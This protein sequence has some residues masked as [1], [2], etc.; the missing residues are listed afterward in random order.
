M[1]V[2]EIS[3][4]YELQKIRSAQDA[5][6]HV[7]KDHLRVTRHRHHTRG[8]RDRAV[9]GDGDC[10]DSGENRTGNLIL[11]MCGARRALATATTLKLR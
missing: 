2:V 9:Q 10:A 7:A 4:R 3:C 1:E 5:D 8:Q 11:A 6:E